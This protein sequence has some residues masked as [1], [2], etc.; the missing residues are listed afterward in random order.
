MNKMI[1][2]VFDDESSAYEGVKAL[3]KTACGG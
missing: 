1:V 3:Q 2:T